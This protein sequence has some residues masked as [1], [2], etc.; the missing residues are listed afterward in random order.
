MV[1]CQI[2]LIIYCFISFCNCFCILKGYISQLLRERGVK[3]IKAFETFLRFYVFKAVDVVGFCVT[4]LAWLALRQELLFVS[5]AQHGRHL[6]VTFFFL[7]GVCLLHFSVTI[8]SSHFFYVFI[9]LFVLTRRQQA[10]HVL[11]GALHISNCVVM[12]N[13]LV[14]LL[15]VSP[16]HFCPALAARQLVLEINK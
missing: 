13:R 16:S 8:F 15:S 1:N 3:N 4:C 7:S 12:A 6:G 9:L 10:T 14:Q 2:I 5:P 11:Q